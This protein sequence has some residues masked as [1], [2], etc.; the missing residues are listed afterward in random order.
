MLLRGAPAALGAA[1][2]LGGAARRGAKRGARARELDAALQSRRDALGIDPSAPFVSTFAALVERL[3][4][5]TP[6]PFDAA[7]DARVQAFEDACAKQYPDTLVDADEAPDARQARL[8]LG[9][10]L[11]AEGARETEADRAADEKSLQRALARR[12]YL[13]VRDDTTGSWRF[14]QAEWESPA[15]AR[16]TLERALSD[17][18]AAD[19][20]LHWVGHAPCAHL[21][22]N[23]SRQFWWRAQVLAGDVSP[24]AG[25]DYAW[26]TSDELVRD[27]C[28]SAARLARDG[29]AESDSP[30]LMLTRR[31]RVRRRR[32]STRRAA[33]ATWRSSSADRT[34]ERRPSRPK[35]A[36]RVVASSGGADY[37]TRLAVELER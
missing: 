12:L 25:V 10:L 36:R 24:P 19:L 22:H 17:A 1:R 2:S 20:E 14:P 32:G 34:T 16:Q 35:R 29:H 18:G 7:H 8:R 33:C 21:E 30:S 9:A 5:L 28:S 27:H 31:V 23:G 13:L 11:D 6:E 4:L 37:G 3:P 15:T 26:L